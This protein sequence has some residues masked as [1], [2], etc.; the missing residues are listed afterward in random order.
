MS[1]GIDQVIPET[2][3]QDRSIP[4]VTNDEAHHAHSDTVQVPFVGAVTAPGGIYTVVFGALAVLTLIEVILFE[5]LKD[6]EGALFAVRSVLLFGISLSKALLVVWF[7][8]HLRIDNPIFRWIMLLPVGLVIISI[9][10]LIGV[11]IA[12]GGG[13]R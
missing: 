10:Y 11:P 5:V 8:M 1:N 6:T 2:E 4:S 12:G 9:V 13:Y 7:Y 3:N